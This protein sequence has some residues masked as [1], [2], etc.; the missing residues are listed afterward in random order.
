MLIT[1]YVKKMKEV[2]DALTSSGRTVT[3]DELIRYITD[4]VGPKFDPLVMY[5]MTKLDFANKKIALVEAKYA[6]Q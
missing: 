4:R 6:L 1:D 3:K 2:G 5:F